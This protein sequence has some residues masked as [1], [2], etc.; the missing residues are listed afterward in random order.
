MTN[1]RWQGSEDG[2]PRG[3]GPVESA[4]SAELEA[5]GFTPLTDPSPLRT[6]AER[7]LS[8]A[9]V[10]D[11]SMNA[12]ALPALDRQLGAVMAEARTASQPHPVSQGTAGDD[13]DVADF[14]EERRRRRGEA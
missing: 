4:I 9:E 12:G 14:E 7:A 10:I 1:R 3:V 6:A 2:E 8:L 5:L 13:P 11:H